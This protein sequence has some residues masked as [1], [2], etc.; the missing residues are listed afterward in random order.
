MLLLLLLLLHGAN[1][2]AFGLR[3]MDAQTSIRPNTSQDS[4]EAEEGAQ[5]QMRPAL[6]GHLYGGGGYRHH[7]CHDSHRRCRCCQTLLRLPCCSDPSHWGSWAKHLTG[8]HLPL[9][10]GVLLQLLQVSMRH[11][12]WLLLPRHNRVSRIAAAVAGD[13]DAASH[14]HRHTRHIH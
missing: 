14:C 2:L 12:R 4:V 1:L 8:L 11:L 5:E 3:G 10:L 9:L 6:P 13:G 7:C